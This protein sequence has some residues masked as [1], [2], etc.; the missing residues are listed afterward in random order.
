MGS[1]PSAQVPDS[2]PPKKS[3]YRR[4]EDAKS[5]RDKTISDED[6]QKYVGMTPDELAKW[7]Q[8]RPGVAGHQNAGS[9]TAGPATGLGGLGTGSGYGGW[10]PDARG[11]LKFPPPQ[12]EQK[13]AE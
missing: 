5:G 6:M 7:S 4:Y 8:G 13:P 3:L 2:T 10:G 9:I 11:D 1:K 12:K